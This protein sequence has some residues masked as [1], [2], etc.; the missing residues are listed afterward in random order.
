MVCSRD[1]KRN[2]E[3]T[4][5]AAEHFFAILFPSLAV[6]TQRVGGKRNESVDRASAR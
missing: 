3:R 1:G 4:H 5:F 2:V 6:A